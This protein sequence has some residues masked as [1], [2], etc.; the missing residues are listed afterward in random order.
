[1]QLSAL[2]TLAET[3]ELADAADQG[4]GSPLEALRDTAAYKQVKQLQRVRLAASSNTTTKTTRSGLIIYM[5]HIHLVLVWRSL[6][7]KSNLSTWT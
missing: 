1:M 4:G 2:C 5:F 7:S 6:G 3:A